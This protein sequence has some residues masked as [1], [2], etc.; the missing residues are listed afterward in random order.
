MLST[1]RIQAETRLWLIIVEEALRRTFSVL[2]PDMLVVGEGQRMW[3]RRLRFDDFDRHA[4]TLY[5]R[6]N[7]VNTNERR[8]TLISC[9][10]YCIV[11]NG[12]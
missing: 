6:G 4:C 12:V 5:C 3:V 10:D 1:V 2:V 7:R 11:L 8:S 9:F